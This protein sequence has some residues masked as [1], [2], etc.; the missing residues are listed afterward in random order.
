M[1]AWPVPPRARPGR[2]RVVVVDG[3]DRGARGAPARGRR[4]R[5][6]AERPTG[7]G[8]AVH[9]AA[10][11][12]RRRRDRSSS[13]NGDVPLV[14]AEAHPRRS[15]RAHERAGAAATMATMELDDPTRLRPRRARRRRLRRARRRDQGAGRRHAPRSS[16]STRSTPASTPSTPPRCSSALDRSCAPTTPRASCYLPDVLRL[17]RARRRAPSR[18]TSS[19]TRRWCSASTTASTSPRSARSPSARILE[20]HHARRRDRRRPGVDAHRRRRDAS[21][22]TPSSSRRPTCAARP[23]PASAA[24]GPATTVTRRDARRRRDVRHSYLDGA[25]SRT[26]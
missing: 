24:I 25:R 16:R 21:A 26:A 11:A 19:T 17:L 7:T 15:S 22:R 6:A 23:S 3:P 14:T 8:G 20:A 9:A 12:H 18:P 5:R 10:R 2:E 1:V 13:L 4:D